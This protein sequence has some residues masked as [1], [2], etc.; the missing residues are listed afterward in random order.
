MTIDL[1]KYR[2]DCLLGT[3]GALMMLVGDLCLSVVPASIGDSGLFAREAYLNGSFGAWRLPLLLA[4]GLIGMSLGFFTVR[5]FYCQIG[6]QYRRT[7]AAILA[8]GV[9]YIA[10]AGVLHFFI[11]SL[12]D[13]IGTLAPLI[14]R[15]QTLA[16]V[17]AQYG[18]VMPAMFISYAGMLL[19]IIGSLYALITNK[20][21]LPRRMF[22]FHMIVWQLVL[23][24]IPDIRQALGAAPSTW[25]FVISQGS[26]NLS[27]AV[28]MLAN[29][30]WAGRQMRVTE[31]K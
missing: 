7:R 18:R 13:W 24:I 9:V 8:G 28:W 12:A 1:K 31:V 3:L 20:T 26:G 14:G 5:A 2:R 10:S 4:T 25:D 23:V 30:I 11:G 29:A 15:E 21:C 17:G 16:L 27:L 6:Q 19:M 22:V